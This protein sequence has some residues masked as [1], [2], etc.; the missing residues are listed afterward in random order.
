MSGL[1][2]SIG[3][4]VVETAAEQAQAEK[5]SPVVR[6]AFARLAELLG[7]A[8]LTRWGGQGELVIGELTVGALSLDELLGP[9]G[10]D[11]LAEQLYQRIVGGAS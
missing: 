1:K 9:R 5:L 2:L 11:R 10:A 6:E 8:P 4:V 7:R 3:E